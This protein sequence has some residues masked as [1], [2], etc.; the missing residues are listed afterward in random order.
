[1]TKLCS[2]CGTEN[3]DEAQFCR[4]CGTAFA[5]ARAAVAAAADGTAANVCTECGFQNKPG[6]RYCA[7]CGMSLAAA[8]EGAGEAAAPAAGMESYS[9][10]GPLPLSYPTFATVAPYPSAPE[11]EPTD[12]SA[13]FD[14]RTTPDIP[15][16]DAAIALRQ[17]EGYEAHG[18]TAASFAQAAPTPNRAPLVLG[19]VVAVLVLAGI[20]AWL[21]MGRSNPA[22][23]Q[24]GVVSAP[25]VTAPAIASAPAA[26]TIIIEEAPAASPSAMAASAAAPGSAMAPPAA[27]PATAGALGTPPAAAA[28]LPQAGDV[29]SETADAEAKR[30]AAEKRRDKAARDKADRDAKAKAIVDQREQSTAAQRAEQDAQARR[31][32][33]EAQRVRPST[34]VPASP[35]PIV[36]AR[37]VR[38]ICAGRGTIAEAVCQSRQ[39][40]LA[41]H[42]NEA[43]CRQLR[44]ADERRRNAQN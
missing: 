26:S 27:A 33:E 44:E 39:C 30:L 40:G 17:Q 11:P 22:P 20:A 24:P 21:F 29:V 13:L 19:I 43:I 16:A 15:D 12:H 2:V 34:A 35:P 18:D 28:P 3:R 4:A 5:A 37:G 36:Q 42:A 41:E 14:D 31:R 23:P 9:G 1:M 6:I 7:N 32:A 8:A 10:L 25:V 38:E